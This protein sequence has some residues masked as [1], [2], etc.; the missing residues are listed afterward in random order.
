MKK[1]IYVNFFFLFYVVNWLEFF[2]LY[3]SGVII[4]SILF[5]IFGKVDISCCILCVKCN[6]LFDCYFKLLFGLNCVI[7]YKSFD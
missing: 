1:M 4:V 5:G 3:R 7:Y 2:F 6:I